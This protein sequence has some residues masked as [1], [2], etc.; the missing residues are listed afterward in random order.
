MHTQNPGVGGHAGAAACRST[1]HSGQ[2]SCTD[3]KRQLSLAGRGASISRSVAG[4]VLPATAA[5]TRIVGPDA[6]PL[7]AR[8]WK[9]HWAQL[10][11]PL[12][13]CSERLTLKY[14]T[15]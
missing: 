11:Q 8:E 3:P 12:V 1:E 7:V 4:L 6:L 5:R 14:R 2:P 9:E 15:A 13:E 10:G